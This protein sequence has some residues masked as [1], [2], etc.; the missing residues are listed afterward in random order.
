MQI[1][2]LLLTYKINQT[3]IVFSLWFTS[4]LKKSVMQNRKRILIFIMKQLLVFQRSKSKAYDFN[5]FIA[6]Q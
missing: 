4:Y 2:K 5:H 3:K 1:H 6:V